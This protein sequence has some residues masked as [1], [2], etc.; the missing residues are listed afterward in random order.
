M[1]CLPRI[2]DKPLHVPGEKRGIA[3]VVAAVAAENS[4]WFVGLSYSGSATSG[5]RLRR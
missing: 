3:V 4:R 5:S 1:H 2:A